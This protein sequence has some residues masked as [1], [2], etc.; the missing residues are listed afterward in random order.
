M[1]FAVWRDTSLDDRVRVRQRA[2][3]L[4]RERGEAIA[5]IITL[6]QGKPI[7]DGRDEVARASTF[8]EWDAAQSLR[9]YGSVLPSGPQMQRSVLKPIGPI[10]AFTPWNVPLSSRRA[11][12]AWPWLPAAP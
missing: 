2:M 10:A 11:T 5:E 6:E 4:L 8:L 3:A 1:G 7:A 9:T 12:S